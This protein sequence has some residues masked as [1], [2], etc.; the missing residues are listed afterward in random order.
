MPLVTMIG[1]GIGMWLTLSMR[2]T[3][4]TFDETVGK[5]T[6]SSGISKQVSLEMVRAIFGIMW[7]KHA[8]K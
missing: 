3:P 1:L 4:G 6:L 8:G 5:E 2:D 7:R